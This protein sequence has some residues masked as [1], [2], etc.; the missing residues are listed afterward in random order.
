MILLLTLATATCAVELP[1]TPSEQA[2]RQVFGAAYARLPAQMENVIADL[3]EFERLVRLNRGR[4]HRA[5][6]QS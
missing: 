4:A 5:K 1:A 6:R 3:T 2:M